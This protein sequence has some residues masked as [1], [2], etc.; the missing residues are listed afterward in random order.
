MNDLTLNLEALDDRR[1]NES[2]R[3]AI[4]LL[5]AAAIFVEL[6]KDDAPEKS[7]ELNLAHEQIETACNQLLETIKKLNSS[8]KA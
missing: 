4:S 3:K 6:S 7:G 8:F 2:I 5:E 1:S